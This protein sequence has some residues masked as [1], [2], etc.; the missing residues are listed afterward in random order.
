[1]NL[2]KSR[3][4]AAELTILVSEISKL[5]K[6]YKASNSSSDLV[7][8]NMKLSSM[9][10]VAHAYRTNNLTLKPVKTTVKPAVKPAE[11]KRP[12]PIVKRRTRE[13]S[14]ASEFEIVEESEIEQEI[15]IPQKK[16][17]IKPQNKRNRRRKSSRK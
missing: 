16:D 1:M 6:D 17:N 3:D 10:R 5:Q 9:T 11:A 13:I 7:K 12:P 4:Y 2:F 8:L 15:E 14:F